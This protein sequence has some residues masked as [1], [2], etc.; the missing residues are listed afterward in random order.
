LELAGAAFARLRDLEAR[1][2]PDAADLFAG[3]AD[4]YAD[5]GAAGR[6]EIM[7]IHKAKGLE[8]DLVVVPALDRFVPQSRDQLLL[9]HQFARTGRDGMIMAARPPIGAASDR[10]GAASD[11]PGAASDRLYE[12]LRHQLRDA[13]ALEAERTSPHRRTRRPAGRVIPGHRARAVCSRFYGPSPA[14]GSLWPSPR[15]H[16]RRRRLT[17][18]R[19]VADR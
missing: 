9:T 16:R 8:F 2:L 17:P 14:P 1:G 6:V 15:C 13:A 11:R 5:H 19:P 18:R 4:L 10:P 12:F 3:F 7:T